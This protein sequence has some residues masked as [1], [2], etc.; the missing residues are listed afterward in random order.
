MEWLF[1]INADLYTAREVWKALKHLA[2]FK[3]CCMFLSEYLLLILVWTL[4]MS[5]H[6]SLEC[7]FSREE[8]FALKVAQ[9]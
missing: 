9:T 8:V 5:A 6:Q 2:F 1:L 4:I 3:T 7:L